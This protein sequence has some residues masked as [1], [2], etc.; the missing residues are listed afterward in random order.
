MPSDVAYARTMQKINDEAVFILRRAWQQHC[1]SQPFSD[2][3]CPECQMYQA[4][5][6]R[7]GVPTYVYS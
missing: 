2:A 4:A 1:W 5:V 3:A 6:Q 7:L